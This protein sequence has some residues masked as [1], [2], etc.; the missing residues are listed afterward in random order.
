M[1]LR[2]LWGDQKAQKERAGK[3]AKVILNVLS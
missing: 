2:P 3:A 1:I